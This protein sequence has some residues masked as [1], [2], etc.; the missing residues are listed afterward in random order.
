MG[1]WGR[2][3]V[4]FACALVFASAAHARP[5]LGVLGNNARFT[6]LS[7]QKSAVHLAFLGWGQGLS[8]GSPFVSLFQTLGPIPM[9]HLDTTAGATEREAITPAQVAAGKGDAYLFA[10]NQAISQWGAG[11]YVRPMAEMNNSANA[12][13]GFTSSG[14]PKPGHSPADY[15]KAFV[16]IYLLLHGGSATTVSAKLQ[17]LG[18]PGV[19]HD[20]ASNPFPR[21]RVVW[22]PLA[23]GSPRIAA[24]A[25]Q[26]YYPGAAYVDVEGVDVYDEAGGAPWAA[27]EDLYRAAVAHH[28]PF[29]IPEFGL[30]GVDDPA[31]V[32]HACR[33]LKSHQV[34]EAS[35]YE[36][37]PGGPFDL[38]TKPRSRAA[39]RSCVPQLGAGL[40]A[41]AAAR[42]SGST[43][44]GPSLGFTVKGQPLGSVSAP[45]GADGLELDMVP[46][47]GAVVK[48]YWIRGGKALAQMTIP[49]GATGAEFQTSS[50][51]TAPTPL[52]RPRAG[53]DFHVR[54][55]GA[56]TITST[57][58]TRVGKLLATIPVTSGETSIAFTQGP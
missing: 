1:R 12:W 47:T 39:Y 54:W 48:G 11:I 35:F 45:I 44:V 2:A 40:P 17:A 33:F 43:T 53:T 27:A 21:L 52:I 6:A 8:Y 18:M 5:L 37:S 24:N 20:L 58:W 25:P 34:R 49:A 42:S 23:G 26:S 50:G 38:A 29:A 57:W 7:G 19:T 51:G 10:L 22:N 13:S 46:S 31:F 56:G 4:A 16:R 15:R 9:I 30:I 36:G 32:E 14:R 28:K 55:N 41:W 3:G